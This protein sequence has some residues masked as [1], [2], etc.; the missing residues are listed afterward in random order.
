MANRNDDDDDGDD[1][2]DDDAAPNKTLNLKEQP[3]PL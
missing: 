2:A 3:F 1:D